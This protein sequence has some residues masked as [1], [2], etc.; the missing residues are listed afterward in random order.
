[1]PS[2]GYAQRNP[3]GL[4]EQV[5]FSFTEPTEE[6][7][8]AGSNWVCIFSSLSTSPFP[9]ASSFHFALCFMAVGGRSWGSGT[10]LLSSEAESCHVLLC[11]F[12]A[13]FLS[14]QPVESYWRS[15]LSEP[16]GSSVGVCVLYRRA[17][18]P[19]WCLLERMAVAGFV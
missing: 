18:D 3:R 9:T 2:K 7:R 11:F 17:P 14:L 13:G 12:K 6:R 16:H 5:P 1:M 4:L 19:A 8:S 10:V 15:P